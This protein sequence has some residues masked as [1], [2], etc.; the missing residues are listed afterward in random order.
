MSPSPFVDRKSDEKESFRW[1]GMSGCR[2]VEKQ[3]LFGVLPP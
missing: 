1:C 3:L 2:K